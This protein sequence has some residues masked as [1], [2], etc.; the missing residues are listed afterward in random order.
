MIVAALNEEGQDNPQ[1]RARVDLAAKEAIVTKTIADFVNSSSCRI[2]AAFRV[3][4]DFLAKD[5]SEWE[6]YASFQS[7]QQIIWRITA[8]N[9]F[10]ERE[11]ALIQD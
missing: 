10:A 3:S 2:F 7:S 5:S 4:M 8:A 1:P 6:N 9:D 11:V